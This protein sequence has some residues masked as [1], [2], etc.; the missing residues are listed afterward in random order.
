VA[1]MIALVP[2]ALSIPHRDHFAY[3]APESEMLV[4]SR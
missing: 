3:Y 4:S 2:A 1:L